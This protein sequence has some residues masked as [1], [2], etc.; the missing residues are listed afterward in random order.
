MTLHIP[1]YFFSVTLW[2]KHRTILNTPHPLNRYTSHQYPPHL[3]QSTLYSFFSLSPF[4]TMNPFITLL[5]SL[6]TVFVK[7]CLLLYTL[8]PYIW[9]ILLLFIHTLSFALHA[10]TSC[11]LSFITLCLHIAHILNFYASSYSSF[12]HTV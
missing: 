7:I 9:R 2:A 4:T 6:P 12:F 10:I 8:L 3:S 1:S 5:T 11:L